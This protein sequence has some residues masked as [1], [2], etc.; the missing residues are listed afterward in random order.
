MSFSYESISFLNCL[1]QVPRDEYK[2]SFRSKG[3]DCVYTEPN[4]L[5]INGLKSK[6]GFKQPFKHIN[7]V[8]QALFNGSDLHIYSLCSD[9]KCMVIFAPC[10]HLFPNKL[11]LPTE[12]ATVNFNI[13]LNVAAE[14]A[15]DKTRQCFSD[16]LL[17]I[18]GNESF[19]FLGDRSGIGCSATVVHVQGSTCTEMIFF[20]LWL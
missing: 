6:T 16:L 5:T 14:I 4:I 7:Q 17:S 15:A 12:I 2:L 1:N 11:Q 20:I 18:F 3:R 19:L 10:V 9:V 13:H 8:N